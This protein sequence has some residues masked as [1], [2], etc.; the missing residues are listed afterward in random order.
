MISTKN[1]CFIALD[2]GYEHG[3]IY[4]YKQGEFTPVDRLREMFEKPGIDNTWCTSSIKSR[5][6]KEPNLQYDYAHM[7]E[8][9]GVRV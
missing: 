3:N 2:L 4:V 1:E 9:R 7:D 8:A 5:F 6:V